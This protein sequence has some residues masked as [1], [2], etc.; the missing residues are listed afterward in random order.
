[1]GVGAGQQVA[2]Q[3]K[4]GNTATETEAF[5]VDRL[6]ARVRR[7]QQT[8]KRECWQGQSDDPRARLRKY[9]Q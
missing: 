8:T 3:A 1:M 2:D 6:A 7:V 9:S 5:P 4:G